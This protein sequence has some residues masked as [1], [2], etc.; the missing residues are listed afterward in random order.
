MSVDSRVLARSAEESEDVD[1]SYRSVEHDSYRSTSPPNPASNA[2]VTDIQTR[3]FIWKGSKVPVHVTVCNQGPYEETAEVILEDTSKNVL[4][5]RQWVTLP[6]E[7]SQVVTFEWKT[8]SF[9]LGNHVLYAEAIADPRP[10][11]P[12]EGLCHSRTESYYSE[13]EVD[14]GDAVSEEPPPGPPAERIEA[15]SEA[16]QMVALAERELE[17]ARLAREEAEKYRSWAEDEAAEAFEAIYEQLHSAAL[18][19][20]EQAKAQRQETEAL[21]RKAQRELEQA[22]AIKAEVERSRKEAEQEAHRLEG[23]AAQQVEKML[24]KAEAMQAEAQRQREAAQRIK[25]EAEVYREQVETEALSQRK[26]VDEQIRSLAEQRASELNQRAEE[27]EQAAV[28]E[29]GRMVAE[30]VLLREIARQEMK[31]QRAY[32]ETIRI[33]SLTQR[34][35][36]EARAKLAKGQ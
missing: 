32:S 16:D 6:P 15:L 13:E 34:C 3:T 25:Y 12:Q 30:L 5:G 7:S 31:A 1:R 23:E 8:R 18:Q 14:R 19:E 28:Q 4:I 10:Y 17:E 21:R 27:L 22:Q 11:D 9:G 35:L 2:V 33:W 36:Q 26:E 29:V 24:A 20:L